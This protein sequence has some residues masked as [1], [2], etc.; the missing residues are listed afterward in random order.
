LVDR[1]EDAADAAQYLSRRHALG[2]LVR[3]V[4]ERGGDF[5][6]QPPF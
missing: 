4:A 3:N 2:Y 5:N 1:P 6:D